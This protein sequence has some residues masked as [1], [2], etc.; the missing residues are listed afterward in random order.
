[1]P[2][3]LEKWPVEMFQTSYRVFMIIEEIN[4]RFCRELWNWCSDMEKIEI[5]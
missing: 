3:A 4:E 1:M 5:Y 2:E